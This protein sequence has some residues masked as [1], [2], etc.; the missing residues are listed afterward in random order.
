[1][2]LQSIEK[3]ALEELNR[4]STLPEI[5]ALYSRFLGRKDGHLTSVLRNLKALPEDEKK[6]VGQLANQVRA[7]LEERF[8]EKQRTLK[9]ASFD[10]DLKKTVDLSLPGR[11]F[12]P[13]HSHPILSTI[14]EIA[15]IFR[16]IGF[17]LVDGP[18]LESDKNNFTDLNIPENHP[19]R[20]MQDTFYVD[21]RDETGKPLLM[22]TQTS[23]IQI[24]VMKG[25]TPPVRIIAPGRVFRHEA[26]DATHAAVF[27]Q[28]EGLAV[29]EGLSFADLKGTLSYFAESY[30]GPKTKV[31]FSP[32]YFPFVEPGAQME[33]SCFGCSGAGK[34]AD[35][36][37]CGICKATGWIEVLGAG[38]VHPQVLRN[39]GY[40]PEKVSGFAFGIGVE[41]I[42]M[43][44]FGVRDIRHFLESDLR[45]LEQFS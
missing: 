7:T 11:S 12:V 43:T 2:D 18:E 40:D 41:R 1:M 20:D 45:F 19:A 9:D 30:F 38:M 8:A 22:R 27:H 24:R 33:A 21:R 44:R 14:R 6:R 35:G 17:D 16:R 26:T 32:S 29:D 25:S 34:L 39:V 31:R 5:E 28:I 42:V 15:D 36:A 3:E 4:S 10:A 37:P 23:P 13:G